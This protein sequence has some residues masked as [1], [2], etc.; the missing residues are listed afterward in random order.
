MQNAL[1][2]PTVLRGNKKQK[3][4]NQKSVLR[5]IRNFLENC[6]I[7]RQLAYKEKIDFLENECYKHYLEIILAKRNKE[8]VLDFPDFMY[9]QN[10]TICNEALCLA[11]WAVTVTEMRFGRKHIEECYKLRT[12]KQKI[13]SKK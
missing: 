7:R 5:Q 11:K 4:K 8:K 3:T 10:L 9:W 1:T 6:K 13:N 2:F 12:Q